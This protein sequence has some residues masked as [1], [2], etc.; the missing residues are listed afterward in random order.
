VSESLCCGRCLPTLFDKAFQHISTP[1]QHELSYD[2]VSFDTA[3]FKR[4]VVDLRRIVGSK[5][6]AKALHV[7]NNAECSRRYGAGKT[8]KLLQG[9]VVEAKE[10]QKAGNSRMS[11]F[12]T[13]DYDCGGG[14]M[15]RAELNI[16]SVKSGEIPSAF[17][18]ASPGKPILPPAPQITPTIASALPIEQAEGDQLN[19]QPCFFDAAEEFAEETPRK[20]R[21]KRRWKRRGHLR[22]RR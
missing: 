14:D 18:A 2:T 15:K 8:T 20:R 13:A 7:T 4:M 5:V 17:P 10:V 21:W 9:T 19:N 16:R 3:Q 11:W 6:H 1:P 22:R 12:I